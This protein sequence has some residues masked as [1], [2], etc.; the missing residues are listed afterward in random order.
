MSSQ[1]SLLVSSFKAKYPNATSDKSLKQLSQVIWRKYHENIRFLLVG[2]GV[3]VVDF[4]LFLLLSS[5]FELAL[6]PARVTAFI[7]SVG[8]SWGI[9][10]SWTFK[11]R[12]NVLSKG[13]GNA[14]FELGNYQQKLIQLGKHLC[15]AS[16]AALANLSLFYWVNIVL[17]QFVD[18]V[19]I[20]RFIGF[21]IG[22]LAGL[23]V[24]WLGANYWTFSK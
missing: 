1:L 23:V 4:N 16:F 17:A 14:S 6:M 20:S 21:A 2:A 11:G 8:L 12:S 15:V 3:F 19:S 18:D 9:N 7:I 10:R 13:H 5:V 24:N 22:V